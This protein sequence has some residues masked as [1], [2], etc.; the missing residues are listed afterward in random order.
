METELQPETLLQHY[1]EENKPFGAV[2]PPIFQNSLFVFPDC[3]SLWDA[4]NNHPAGPPYHYSRM[5]NPTLDIAERKIA[6]LEGMESAKLFS[7]GMAAISTAI[8]NVVQAGS[9]C[10]VADT[11]YGPVRLMFEQMLP[12]YGVS[13]TFVDGRSVA[14]V[15]DAIKPE[16]SLIYLESPSS[17]VFRLQ[18]LAAIARLAGEKG[19]V[20][21]C[22]NTNATPLFQNPGRLG[23]DIVVHSATKYLAGHSDVTGGVVCCSRE[24]MDSILRREVSILSSTMAP[25]AAWLLLRGMRT[26]RLRVE[27]H[28][29]SAQLVAEWLSKSIEVEEVYYTG[30]ASFP[31]KQLYESQMS[32]STSL[33][34]FQPKC[35]DP[36][37]VKRLADAARIFQ[38]GVSWGGFESL[39]VPLSV[40][41]QD[42]PEARLLIRLHVGLES[43]IDLI[44]DLEWSFS[45]ARGQ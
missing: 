13:H 35:Q 23:V 32:G 12:R 39:I 45:Q 9:H 43:P 10:V 27:A 37:Y 3:E 19:I 33:V 11:C 4:M 1:A 7:G 34:T 26:L 40:H 25:F 15:A 5:A 21:I 8:L 28:Q 42:W 31:Q 41:P 17:F 29:R 14:A 18:D 6:M 30:L 22:D 38:I 16:T 44:R 2:V 20:T 36:E 24:R